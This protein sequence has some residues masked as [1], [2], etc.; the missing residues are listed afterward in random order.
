MPAAAQPQTPQTVSAPPRRSLR[1]RL[2]EWAVVLGCLFVGSAYL[3]AEGI[4]FAGLI[5]EPFRD[6]LR[7]ASPADLGLE[8]EDISIAAADG[9]ELRGWFIP[10]ADA[11]G[12]TLIILHGICDSKNR[13]LDRVTQ[14]RAVADVNICLMDL[15]GH[16]DSGGWECTYGLRETGDLSAV[17]DRL[18]A[19]KDVD[20]KKIGVLGS[21]LGAAIALLTAA[22]DGRIAAVVGEGAYCDFDR[23]VNERGRS[24]GAP[25]PWRAMCDRF[26]RFRAGWKWSDIDVSAAAA[27]MKCPVLFIHGDADDQTDCDHSRVLLAACSSADKSLWLVPGAGHVGLHHADEEGYRRRVGEFLAGALGK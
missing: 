24:F 15:R 3:V 12:R 20:A 6:S 26:F 14:I 23:L 9:I 2:V 4:R 16:G 18:A 25:L 10:H 13:M 19:R 8:Y 5:G 11:G 22:R 1:R 17:L 27:A 7:D 21:S